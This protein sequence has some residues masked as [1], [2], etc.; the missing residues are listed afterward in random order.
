MDAVSALVAGLIS[1][2]R[3]MLNTDVVVGGWAW[4]ITALGVLVG[5]LPAAGALLVAIWRK[6][7]GSRYGPGTAAG[8]TVIGV[9]S[10][11]LLPWLAFTATGDVVRAAAAGRQV[12]GL[13]ESDVAALAEPI[14]VPFADLVFDS[15]G[16]YLGGTTVRQAFDP[17]DPAAFALAIGVLA[18]LPLIVAAFVWG[19]ARIALRRGPTWPV[20]LFWLPALALPL[21]TAATP[22]GSSGHLWIGAVGGAFVGLFVVLLAGRPSRERVRRSLEPA[23]ARRP[24]GPPRGSDPESRAPVRSAPIRSRPVAPTRPEDVGAERSKLAERFAARPPEPLVAPP[25][26][27][28][29]PTP[30]LVAPGPLLGGGGGGGPRFRMIRRLG[31]GGF[32]KVWLAHDAQLGHEVALKAAHAPDVETEE[33]I[34]REFTALRSV[35]HPNCVRVFDLVSARSDPGLAELD[36]MVIV[37]EH[38]EGTPLGELV[39]TRGVLDDIAAAR[40]WA[41]VAGALDDAHSRGVMHRDVKPGNVIVDAA[42]YAHLIDFGIA[43]RT[44]DATLTVAGFVL[45]TPDFLAPEVAG[46]QRATPQSDSWQLAATISYAL[47]GHPPR[48][49]HADAVSGLRAAAAGA[50]LTQLPPRSAHTALLHAAMHNDPAQRPPLGAARQALEDWLRRTGAAPDGPVTQVTTRR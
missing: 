30:T 48:G 33:R 16:D 2:L 18:V 41:S 34:R 40:A 45:G 47:S 22:A 35:R 7:I 23:A 8:L 14:P 25:R 28:V 24:A 19:Q 1:G 39:R 15:Q 29:G 13:R 21:L 20:H 42:G 37:M 17:A 27:G 3:A 9:V 11:G 32:G 6:G 38:V 26:A 50:P 49:T 46:G 4:A 31:A 10:A 12:T 43:R 5:L 44:G 36:G